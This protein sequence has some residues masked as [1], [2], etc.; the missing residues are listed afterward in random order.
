MSNQVHIEL[1]VSQTVHRNGSRGAENWNLVISDNEAT[2]R[3]GIEPDSKD[4][5]LAMTAEEIIVAAATFAPEIMLYAKDS[6]DGVFIFD[7]WTT[8]ASIEA[9]G[10]KI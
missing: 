5:Y 8:W 2:V 1:E 10:P 7:E 4:D 3:F 9:A 6:L